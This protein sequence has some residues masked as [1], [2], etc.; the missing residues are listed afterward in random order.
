MGLN[1]RGDSV[2]VPIE[3]LKGLFKPKRSRRFK[4]YV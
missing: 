4:T 2:A 1:G 3:R